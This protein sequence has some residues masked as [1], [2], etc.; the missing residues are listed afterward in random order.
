MKQSLSLLLIAGA[1]SASA[2]D[3]T[4]TFINTVADGIIIRRPYFS[5]SGK[6]YSVTLDAETELTPYEDGSLFRFIKF[7]QGEMRLRQSSFS[8]EVRFDPDS[9]SRYE[10]AARKLLPQAAA[11]VTLVDQVK[12]PWPINGW[13][14]HRFIFSYATATGEV[15]ESITFLNIT[16]AQQVIVQ[17]YAAAKDFPDVSSRGYDTIRRWHE[18]DPSTAVRGN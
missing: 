2:L 18:L 6:K 7:K 1:F 8:P 9:L 17:V 10:E 11:K 14:S 16:P 13:Q 15:Q 3:L 4:P 12:N 5:D